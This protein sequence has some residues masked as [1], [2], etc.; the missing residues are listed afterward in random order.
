M[1]DPDAP[2]TE[3]EKRHNAM[4]SSEIDQEYADM[5]AEEALLDHEAGEMHP[6]VEVDEVRRH[7]HRYP[8]TLGP[9]ATLILHR[10]RCLDTATLGPATTDPRRNVM[11]PGENALADAINTMIVNAGLS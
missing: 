4:T 1:F 9:R 5:D 3:T 6:E 8:R 11:R 10:T 7:A 2:E